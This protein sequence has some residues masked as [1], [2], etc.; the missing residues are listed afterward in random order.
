MP[1][2]TPIGSTDSPSRHD[3]FNLLPDIQPRRH[4]KLDHPTLIYLDL[5]CH[6]PARREVDYLVLDLHLRASHAAWSM[7]AHS[8]SNNAAALL[9]STILLWRLVLDDGIARDANDL[10]VQQAVAGQRLRY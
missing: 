2:T 6:R 4:H 10:A 7:R 3:S 9:R 1:W 8:I 5:D